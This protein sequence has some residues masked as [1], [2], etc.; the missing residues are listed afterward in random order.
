MTD[1]D[2]VTEEEMT[3]V[4]DESKEGIQGKVRLHGFITRQTR[5]PERCGLAGHLG[6]WFFGDLIALR[7]LRGSESESA[8]ESLGGLQF[9]SE[10]R[11]STQDYSE[12]FLQ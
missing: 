2:N 1:V 3:K 8:K 10:C 7:A 12:I 5:L 6:E 4:S 11:N 9:Q